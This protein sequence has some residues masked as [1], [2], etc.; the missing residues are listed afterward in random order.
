MNSSVIQA[1]C[2][3]GLN[4]LGAGTVSMIVTSPPYNI[5]LVYKGSNDK[6]VGYLDWMQEVFI[7]AKQALADSGHFFLQMGGIVT[8]PFIPWEVLFR[9][10]AAG[11]ILQNE[12]VWVKNISLSD[13]A[14]DSHGQFKPIS[15][16]RFLNNTHEFIFHL[17]KTGNV[18]VNRLA[19]GVPL[20]WK[21]NLDRFEHKKD[22]RCRG[23]VWFIPYDTIQSKE[24][25]HNHPAVFPVAL[26][27]MCIKFSGVPSGSLVVDPF[28]GIG[29]TLIACKR[30]GMKGLGFDISPEY[31]KIAEERLKEENL[32]T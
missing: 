4:S 24:D 31:C 29:T 26:P 15:S 8:R 23:N 3:D 13:K 17:T 11:F 5:G 21:C 7:A 2:I 30:L 27:E 32:P 6:K 1:D 16:K 9:A 12:I 18:E 19:V 14:E 10:I 22:L 28:M 25:R 20:K